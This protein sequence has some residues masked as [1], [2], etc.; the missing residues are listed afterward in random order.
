MCE[1][2]GSTAAGFYKGTY[3]DGIITWD[4]VYNFP[5]HTAVVNGSEFVIDCN[6]CAPTYY[7]PGSWSGERGPLGNSS[8]KIAVGIQKNA[9]GGISLMG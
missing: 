6:V 1:K 5:N 8:K 2:R 7:K 4:E 9:Y 3:S